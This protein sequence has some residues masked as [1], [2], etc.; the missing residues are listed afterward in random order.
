MCVLNV[1]TI[2][3]VFTIHT[4]ASGLGVGGV[5]RN[6]TIRMSHRQLH[7]ADIV[8]I[9]GCNMSHL[10]NKQRQRH[11][12]CKK[13]TICIT[14][15]SLSGVKSVLTSSLCQYPTAVTNS[16]NSLADTHLNYKYTH[17]AVD[18]AVSSIE[19]K[20]KGRAYGCCFD[21]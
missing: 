5:L 8:F 12:H 14:T 6:N 15:F 20:T 19:G 16:C 10:V 1:S 7:D 9:S 18:Q 17:S 21:T 2:A 4:V 11:A 13:F 3:D